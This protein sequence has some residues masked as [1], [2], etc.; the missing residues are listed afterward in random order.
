MTILRS[1]YFVFV[2]TIRVSTRTQYTPFVLCS[3]T[4]TLTRRIFPLRSRVCDGY[5]LYDP[6]SSTV[7]FFL[8]L[9]SLLISS[10]ES[11][12]ETGTSAVATFPYYPLRSRSAIKTLHV[13]GLFCL[14]ADL[15][16]VVKAL[17][18]YFRSRHGK[19]SYTEEEPSTFFF[20]SMM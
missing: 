11:H 18:Q 5:Q 16:D 4:S 7:S 13:N 2:P 15:F 8:L 9:F 3:T 1:S 12:H 6:E 19:T 17:K 20:F 10:S 14:C